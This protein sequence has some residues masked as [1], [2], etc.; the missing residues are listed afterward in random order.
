[1]EVLEGVPSRS[2][3]HSLHLNDINHLEVNL[4]KEAMMQYIKER[5]AEALK[6]GLQAAHTGI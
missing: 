5:L 2:E 1:M 6:L 3:L 4:M